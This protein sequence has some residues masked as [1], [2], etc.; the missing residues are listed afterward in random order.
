MSNLRK[1]KSDLRKQVLKQR[2]QI[3]PKTWQEKSDRIYKKVRQLNEYQKAEVVHLYV[4][5]NEKNEVATGQLIDDILNSGKQ[6]VVPVTNF[7]EGTL[8]HSLLTNIDILKENDWG[9]KEPTT[10][11]E[12]DISKLD[13][14][15]IP[16]VA[17]D[18]NRNR[19][20]Y[21]KGFY[22]RFLQESSAFK[23]GMI[24]HEF[25]FEEIPTEPFDVKLDA[26]ITD[27]EVIFT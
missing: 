12:F 25:L 23:A 20:G 27:R 4:S 26:I 9:V 16:M 15:L 24:F 21:G 10:I 1:Q 18:R 2:Q 17:A 3:N 19:L 8:T 6:L 7:D 22:D 14:I 13:I 11:N 5:M